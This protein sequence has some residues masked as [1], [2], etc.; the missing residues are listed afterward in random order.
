MT[1]FKF[2]TIIEYQ[3][4]G[5]LQKSMATIGQLVWLAIIACI[6]CGEINHIKN[7]GDCV[8]LAEVQRHILGTF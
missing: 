6:A 8:A 3:D 7:L 2:C 5:I 4:L 1:D